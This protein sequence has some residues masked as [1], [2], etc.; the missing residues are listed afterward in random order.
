MVRK[1]L[2]SCSPNR[3]AQLSVCHWWY[4]ALQAPMCWCQS[5]LP[6]RWQWC[7]M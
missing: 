4:D 5:R 3:V 7:S 6:P 2:I 1:K